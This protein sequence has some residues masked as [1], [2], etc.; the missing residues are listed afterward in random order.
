M[1]MVV[2][3]LFC[4]LKPTP[5]NMFY[6]RFCATQQDVYAVSHGRRVCCATQQ[7]RLLCHTADMSTVSH[8]RHIWGVTQQA[9]LLCPTADMPAVPQSR[10]VCCVAQQ[11]CLLCHTADSLLHHTADMPSA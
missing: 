7:M 1:N 9:C 10:H 5:R 6:R 11:T 2:S 3:I 8:S 4:V